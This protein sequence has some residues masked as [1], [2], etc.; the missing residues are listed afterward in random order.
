MKNW[1]GSLRVAITTLQEGAKKG[2]PSTPFDNTVGRY[3][4]NTEF[5]E[6]V[7]KIYRGIIDPSKFSRIYKIK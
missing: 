7:R 5:A 4:P 2:N 6:E 3:N 1:E